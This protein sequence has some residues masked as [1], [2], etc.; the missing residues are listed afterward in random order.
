MH[1]EN[2]IRGVKYDPDDSQIMQ[3]MQRLYGQT[4]MANAQ[5]MNSLEEM[6]KDIRKI[7]QKEKVKKACHLLAPLT[8]GEI[9]LVDCYE[10]GTKKANLF[11]LNLTGPW[12]V[13][14]IK[15][16]GEEKSDCF[17]IY[18][19]KQEYVFLHPLAVIK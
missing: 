6:K 15:V 1:N 3:N 2:L 5:I 19:L 12:E 14:K 17:G 13:Y 7:P 18:F 10:D 9:C 11:I 8:N 4:M 16:K